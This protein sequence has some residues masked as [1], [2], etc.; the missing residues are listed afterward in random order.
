M[1][2]AKCHPQLG[3]LRLEAADY[4]RSLD[5]LLAERDALADATHSGPAPAY[6]R[7]VWEQELPASPPNPSPSLRPHPWHRVGHARGFAHPTPVALGRPHLWHGTPH[8]CGLTTP[9]PCGG[10]APPTRHHH[11]PPGRSRRPPRYR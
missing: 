3:W 2:V 1:R 5:R 8:T 7:W 6:L 9:C 4:S 11:P 10:L